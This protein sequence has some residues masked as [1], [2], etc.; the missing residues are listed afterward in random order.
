MP[1][2]VI[3]DLTKNVPD[4]NPRPSPPHLGESPLKELTPQILFG[5]AEALQEM[6]ET[7]LN[8]ALA[9]VSLA[10]FIAH[11]LSDNDFEIIS[12]AFEFG[13][14]HGADLIEEESES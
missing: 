1:E 13:L 12:L 8:I 11:H 5:A 3:I 10:T 9:A 4:P 2:R 7:P 6:G 14:E